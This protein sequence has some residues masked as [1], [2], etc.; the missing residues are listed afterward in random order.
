MGRY[1][2]RRIIER[3]PQPP[4]SQPPAIPPESPQ[5]RKRRNPF[6][7]RKTQII[8]GLTVLSL[9]VTA[10]ITLW[11]RK[12]LS[13]TELEYFRQQIG[14]IKEST[15][16]VK[17]E[18]GRELEQAKYPNNID[19][20]KNSLLKGLVSCE[21][22]DDHVNSATKEVLK[23]YLDSINQVRTFCGDYKDVVDYARKVSNATRQFITYD[24]K[25]LSDGSQNNSLQDM[26]EILDYTKI[27]LSK[28]QS[29][30]LQDPALEEMLIVV[31][32]LQKLAQETSNKKSNEAL[33][34]FANEAA[35]QQNNLMLARNYFWNTTIKLKSMDRSISRLQ[36]LFKDQE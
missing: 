4:T 15:E 22:I 27:D 11:P 14:I 17:T 16:V 5:K 1:I 13:Q 32:N 23:P 6:G 10:G 35:K 2:D 8:T 30:P 18:N 21:Q 34:A 29:Y 36:D 28:L 24:T 31:E 3:G 26:V 7:Q 25:L 33:V 12:T 19:A 20:Y 9:V